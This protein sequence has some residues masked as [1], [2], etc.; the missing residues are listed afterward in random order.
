M[1]E[2]SPHVYNTEKEV[3]QLTEEITRGCRAGGMEC[4]RRLTPRLWRGCA[5]S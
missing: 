2:V 1:V 4:T 5:K 3:D